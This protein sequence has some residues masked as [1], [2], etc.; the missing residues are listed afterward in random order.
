MKNY[1]SFLGMGIFKTFR[2]PAFLEKEFKGVAIFYILF[3]WKVG[4]FV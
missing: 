2:I 4:E 1:L 3:L